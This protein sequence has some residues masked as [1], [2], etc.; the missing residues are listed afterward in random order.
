M[1]NAYCEPATDTTTAMTR[2]LYSTPP[3]RHFLPTRTDFRLR[4]LRSNNRN[5]G[6]LNFSITIASFSSSYLL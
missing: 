6:D 5:G 1:I 4:L 3:L 2:S